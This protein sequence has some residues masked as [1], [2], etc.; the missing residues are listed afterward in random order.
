MDSGTRAVVLRAAL[1]EMLESG[2]D[3]LTT[4]SIAARAGVECV[5]ITG[6]WGDRRVLFLE[7]AIEYARENFVV[8]DNGNL[9]D[10]L[11]G[12]AAALVRV[13][14]P[15]WFARAL[16]V[17]GDADLS[18]IRLDYWRVR[19]D[20]VAVVF[21]R[22]ADRGDPATTSIRWTPSRCSSARC[23]RTRSSPAHRCGRNTSPSWSTSSSAGSAGASRANPPPRRFA[24]LA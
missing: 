15:R 13:P 2:L 20:D 22:A 1:E 19:A 5:V 6:H 7:A 14:H 11:L 21:R 3:D 23:C 12:V 18:E 8:P 16:A 17:G 10:D 9:R 4:E 24:C